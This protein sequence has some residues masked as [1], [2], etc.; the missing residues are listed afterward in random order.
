MTEIRT[1]KNELREKYKEAR[2]LIPKEKRDE[3]DK[4]ISKRFSESIT[5]NY[6][7][8]ILFYASTDDEI[9]TWILLEKA[10]SDG[11]KVYFPKC[12]EN[13]QMKFFRI[14]SKDDLKKGMFGLYEPE[15]SDEEFCTKTLNSICIVPGLLFDKEGYRIG[16]GRG[17]YD[18]FL[19]KFSG[20]SVGLCYREL[21]MPKLPRGH[22]D[23]HV[24]IVITEK[25][26]H[27]VNVQK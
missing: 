17:F 13:S 6:S 26:V 23:R 8:S 22:F 10:L 3:F 16:Y 7:D 18:R 20:V 4:N 12:Y 27:A 21:F 5:Y 1:Q 2:R 25:G 19:S 14:N 24:D 11:K 15:E 9:N